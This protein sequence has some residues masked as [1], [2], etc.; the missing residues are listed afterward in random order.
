MTIALGLEFFTE[1][2]LTFLVSSKIFLISC[3][4]LIDS[5]VFRFFKDDQEFCEKKH[6]SQ[7]NFVRKSLHKAGIM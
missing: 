6:D 1:G 3:K 4:I 2:C 7:W 5:V